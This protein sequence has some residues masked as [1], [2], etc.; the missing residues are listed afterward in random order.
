MHRRAVAVEAVE[1][2]GRDIDEELGAVVRQRLAE[3]VEDLD[4]QSLRV[5]LGLEHQRRHGAHQHR[6]GDPTLRL[7]EPG[8]V[9]RGLAAAGRMA[10]MD[11]IAQIE[12]LGHRRG[13]R[14]IMIHVVAFRDLGRT[15][16]AAAVMGDDAVAVR[17]EEQ[18]LRV[19][20][21]GGE[22]PSVME[23]DRLGVLGAPILVE[24]LDAVFGGDVGHHG[25]RSIGK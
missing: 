9:A 1:G 15:A 18:H 5:G 19:P 14:R 2:A 25:L 7:T 6:L 21:V 8:D 17:D 10:D 3:A 22:R 16:V 24:D 4:R 20:I 11:G 13:I 12:M 23:H